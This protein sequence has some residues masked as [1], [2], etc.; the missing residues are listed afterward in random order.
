MQ[1]CR[2]AIFSNITDVRRL[3]TQEGSRAAMKTTHCRTS[4]W[5]RVELSKP[6]SKYLRNGVKHPGVESLTSDK[7]QYFVQTGAA[8]LGTINRCSRYGVKLINVTWDA[9]FTPFKH[10]FCQ[11]T[12][13]M[14]WAQQ[15]QL[16]Y[17]KHVIF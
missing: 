14:F 1:S 17:K 16:I 11:F 5:S 3:S 8:Q 12:Q 4:Q 7:P 13:L 15:I 2:H 10:I 9:S 6:L